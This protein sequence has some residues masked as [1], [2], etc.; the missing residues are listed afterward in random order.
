MDVGLSLNVMNQE[1]GSV[2][3]YMTVPAL[4]TLNIALDNIQYAAHP[5]S[6]VFGT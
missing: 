3:G 4:V 5:P 1:N 2:A 6:L